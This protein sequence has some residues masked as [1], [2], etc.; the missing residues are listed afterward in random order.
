MLWVTACKCLFGFLQAGYVR[1]WSALLTQALTLLPTWCMGNSG[2]TVWL[3]VSWRKRSRRPRRMSLARGC[4][5]TY[6][7][8]WGT[9]AQL[10]QSHLHSTTG[11]F[12]RFILHLSEWDSS[13]LG[14]VCQCNPSG[15]GLSRGQVNTLHRPQLLHQGSATVGQCGL[16]NSPIKMLD[17]WQSTAYISTFGFLAKHCAQ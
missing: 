1:R 9:C 11:L 10:H 6:G 2:L 13:D 7:S 8:Q 3:L 16:L 4:Q 14:L 12:T 5:Y 17:W 15:F